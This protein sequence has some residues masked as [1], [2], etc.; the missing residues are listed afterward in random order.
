MILPTHKGWVPPEIWRQ[1]QSVSH[2]GKRHSAETRLKMSRSMKDK[3]QGCRFFTEE[4]R[5]NLGEANKR[6]TLVTKE[7]WQKIKE[8][9]T[10]PP[11]PLIFLEI[12][13]A[14]TERLA[15]EEKY[16]KAY[17]KSCMHPRKPSVYHHKPLP[18]LVMVEIEKVITR[19]MNYEEGLRKISVALTGRKRGPSSEETRRK[20][21]KAHKGQVFTP[22]WK[23]KL[24]GSNN[25]K[26]KNGISF[27]PYSLDWT[28]ELRHK[29]RHR[30]G[31]Q[32]QL[33]GVVY[34]RDERAF[35]VHHINYNKKCSLEF[36]LVTLCNPCNAYVNENRTYWTQ[37]FQIM[38][39][40]RCESMDY[41]IGE[42]GAIV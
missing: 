36:N 8:W 23:R 17:E 31:F 22:E 1:H 9:Q 37:Y 6:R 25:H 21:S 41:P 15:W 42:L 11:M 27:E 4:H 5:R 34:H 24:S 30:D 12:E 14:I 39:W 10:K 2:T 16:R 38:I 33:C 26:W 32:C 40:K 13:M 7:T 20:Q 18:S 29:I 19:Q 35:C 28:K 3:G